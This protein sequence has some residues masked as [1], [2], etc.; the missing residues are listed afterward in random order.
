[1]TNWRDASF[2]LRILVICGIAA[3]AMRTGPLIVAGAMTPGYSH[4]ANFN[5]ELSA[6]GAAYHD[7]MTLVLYVVG[8]LLFL[9][10]LGLTR[11]TRPSSVGLWG[12]LV[13]AATGVAFVLIGVFPCDPGCSLQDPSS[14]MKAHLLA[15]FGGM[16]LQTIA[17][18]IFG[19]YGRSVGEDPRI[20]NIS[21][22]L[23]SVLV[24]AMAW[25]YATYL[26]LAH[27]LPNP[28]IAQKVF[29]LAA[30]LWLAWCAILMIRT[31]ANQPE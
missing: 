26:G 7:A 23:G 18:V 6:R 14:T 15:G 9:F 12:S 10:A 21:K 29:T 2:G 27:L 30:D 25:L 31:Q 22:L 17:I 19:F 11:W 1:M 16:S 28:V 13:L 20:G 5:S 24:L 8:V 3:A 4:L